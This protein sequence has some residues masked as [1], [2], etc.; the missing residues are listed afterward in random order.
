MNKLR[1]ILKLHQD[2]LTIASYTTISDLVGMP[3]TEEELILLNEHYGKC[4]SI[5]GVKLC[6]S[7]EDLY[8][9]LDTDGRW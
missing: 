9:A 3:I 2:A 1:S 4:V 6:A 7:I 5:S 8:A